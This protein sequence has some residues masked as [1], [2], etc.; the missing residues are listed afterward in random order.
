MA[1]VGKVS[2]DHSDTFG[3]THLYTLGLFDFASSIPR[4]PLTSLSLSLHVTFTLR[5]FRTARCQVFH[6]PC[7]LT[8]DGDLLEKK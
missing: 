2:T 4:S 8:P 6:S 5:L 3:V 7:M 1:T